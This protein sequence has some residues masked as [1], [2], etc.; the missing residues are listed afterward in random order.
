MHDVVIH[1]EEA[2]RIDR[3][4]ADF[5][6]ESSATEALLIDRG[7]QLLA[8]SGKSSFDTVSIGALAAGAFSSTSA[9]ASLLGETEFSVLFHQGVRESI[10]V[11]TVDD[12]TILLAIFG[13]RTTV[14][15]VRLFAKE[16]SRAIQA[17]L[18][19]SRARP[20]RVGALSAPLTVD[21]LRS[22][23]R[24]RSA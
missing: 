3:I 15:M 10:H 13:E 9:I 24:E 8:S 14:G 6:A 23:I 16:A 22:P 5:L 21:E 12:Q 11:S 4:L 1:A 2:A 20:Q 7:G 19:A 18:E 17:V